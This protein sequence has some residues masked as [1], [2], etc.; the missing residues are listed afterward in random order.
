M[1]LLQVIGAIFISFTLVILCVPPILRIAREKNLFEDF[2]QRKVHTTLVPPLGGVA[3]FIGFVLSSIITSYGMNFDLLKYILAA[4]LIMFFIG[5]KDDLINVSAKKKLMIQIFAATLLIVLGNVRITNFH[6]L[7]GINE[8][9]YFP[10]LM[11]SVII[12][13][14]IINAY[15]L[16]DGVD[17]LASGLAIMAAFVFG[18]WFYFAGNYQFAVIAMALVGSLSGF[19]LYNVFGHSNKLFMGDTGSLITGIVISILVI[20][21]NELSL[22]ATTFIKMAA[23]PMVSFAVIIIPLVDTIR[24]FA[25][26]VINKKSPFSADRNHIHHGLLELW[27]HHLKV[28]ASLLFVSV[29]MIGFS[30]LL[31]QSTVNVNVQFLI[32]FGLG[33]G[34]SFVPSI[35]LKM[36]ISS[37]IRLEHQ[38]KQEQKVAKLV[39]KKYSFSMQNAETPVSERLNQF[40]QKV[41]KLNSI[42]KIGKQTKQ[43]EVVSA[44]WDDEKY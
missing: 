39:V 6:G 24:V 12:I 18:V 26:R 15:N 23:T 1:E 31:S 3:I 19:F 33:M 40:N 28:T 17:G 38:I 2:E 14:A 41:R 25:I 44:K 7:I 10:G 9:G 34:I 20:Q 32:V 30:M 5:L 35:L 37:A 22:T 36:K 11:I 42:E 4:V 43:R 16:I 29:F 8:I 21:F 13:V 27:N